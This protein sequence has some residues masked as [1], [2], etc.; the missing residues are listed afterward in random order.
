MTIYFDNIYLGKNSVVAG[1]YINNGPLKGHFDAIYNDFYDGENTFEDCEIKEAIKCINILIN[2]YKDINIDI[3]L[4]TDLINQLVI[5][6]FVANNIKIP[7]MGVYNACATFVEEIILGSSLLNNKNINN[8]LC[9]TSAHNLTAERQYRNPIEYGGPKPEY[10]TFT[11]SAATSFILTKEREDIKVESCTIGKVYD[12]G[13]KDSFDMGSAMASSAVLTLIKHLEDTKR[14]PNYYDLILTGDL[15]KY[16]KE[17]FKTMFYKEK[18]IE[19]N[20][21][22]DSGVL[23]Y[24]MNDKEVLAGGSGP[25]CLPSYYF[26]KIYNMMKD[27]KI[28]KVL[29][30][31]TGALLNTTSVNQKKSI[32]SICHAVSLEAL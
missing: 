28:K 18:G 6:N 7:Y 13:I 14:D 2:K 27:K 4:S 19:L 22:N 26:S 30:L 12:Y 31:A 1:P 25:S 21:Y 8:V 17:I 32:P 16:G 29:L 11:V 23:V 24:D 5:S 9:L 20:N 3:F 10:A 15:G